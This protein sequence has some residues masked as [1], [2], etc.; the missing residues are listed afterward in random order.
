M[1]NRNIKK[2]KTKGKVLPPEAEAI[3]LGE[4]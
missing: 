1:K 4:H 2:A 3:A